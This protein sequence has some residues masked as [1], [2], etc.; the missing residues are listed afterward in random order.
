MVLIVLLTISAVFCKEMVVTQ[1]YTDYL[2]RHVDWEVVDYEENIFRGWTVDEVKSLLIQ[3]VPQFDELLPNVEADTALP[4]KLVWDANCTHEVRDHGGNCVSSWATAAA[5]M[6][7]DRCCIHTEK[8]EGLLSPQEIISCGPVDLGC[9][10][11]WPTSALDYVK[12]AEGLVREACFPFKA[13]NF[14]CPSSCA[15][16]TDWKAAHV[17]KCD[18]YSTCIGVEEMKTCLETGPITIAFNVPQSFFSY[19]SG[20]YK[21]SGSSL[22]LH[23][24]VATGHSDDPECH[25]I[26]RNS[27][28]ER[29]GLKG[30]ILM[31]CQSCGSDG[32]YPNGNVMCDKVT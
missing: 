27:W 26:I 22:G 6:L 23:V 20:I 10:G 29:W 11:G 1:E 18:K 8:D 31:A 25:W 2:K 3:D 21:C 12:E 14:P 15:D 5:D 4:S 16:K 19:K 24:A 30:Y 9:Q 17:C 32:S 7:A 28:G 13:Q